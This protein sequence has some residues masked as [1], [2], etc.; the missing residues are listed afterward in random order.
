VEPD[1][2]IRLAFGNA[3]KEA[4]ATVEPE[5]WGAPDKNGRIAMTKRTEPN[6]QPWIGAASFGRDRSYFLALSYFGA[7][8]KLTVSVSG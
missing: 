2:T 3:G 4:S 5:G 8:G 1:D 6:I 7:S